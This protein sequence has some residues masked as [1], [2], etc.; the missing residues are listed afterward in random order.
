MANR[1]LPAP[2]RKIRESLRLKHACS[3][4]KREIARSCNVARSTVANYLMRARA[5]GELA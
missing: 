5:A 1:G 2:V 4:S 3:L